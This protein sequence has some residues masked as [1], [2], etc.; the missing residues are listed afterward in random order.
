MNGIGSMR[1]ALLTYSTKPR[2]S[3][4]HTL[5]LADALHH[6]GHFVCIYALDKDGQGFGRSLS[7]SYHPVPA[8]AAP[9]EIDRLIHQRINEFVN[10]L[11]RHLQQV[12]YDIFHA[13]DCLSANALAVLRQH[14]KIPQFVRTV[15]HIEDYE[16]VYLQQCQ[17]RS[18]YEP[19]LCLCVS[20]YWQEQ[21]AQHY[22]IHAPRVING[23]NLNR[24]TSKPSH[25]DLQ[26]K[27]QLG[28][29]GNPIFLTVGGIEPRKNTLQLVKAFAQVRQ[30]LPQAQ[31]VIAGGATLFDYQAY[32]EQFFKLVRELGLEQAIILPGVISDEDLPMLY[33]CANS[34]VFPSIKEG[35]GLV[36]FEAIA[37]GLPTIVSHQA[38][39]TE[40]L[41]SE[42]TLFVDPANVHDIAQAMVNSIQPDGVQSL[43]Q[44][45]RSVIETY[46]WQ[47]SA[48]MHLNH[49]QQLTHARNSLSNPV[50]QWN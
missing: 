2:G 3:V 10:G 18:I 25:H 32:R 21:L 29:R 1:I 22:R 11:D 45:S 20:D 50:A 15:H 14:Q 33:R 44:N 26:L 6:A 19:D 28:L 17:E 43:V 30:T 23:V 38:P 36:V 5:E 16:S 7:C 48:T 4:I 31:L 39:F 9:P 27:Q 46:S 40:F 42:Q 34:F 12:H 41:T 35:W 47:A 8:S 13:Q 49:Y 24:F 37:S